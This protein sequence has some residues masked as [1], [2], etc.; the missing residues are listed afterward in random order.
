[1]LSSVRHAAID[2]LR[3][4][5]AHRQAAEQASFRPP[6]APEPPVPA[7]ERRRVA[8]AVDSLPPEQRAVIELAYFQGLSQTQIA[9]RLGEPLGTVKTRLR[10]GM[11]RLRQALLG[12]SE[13]PT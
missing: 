2:R 9:E 7:D 5:E 6:P 3:R 4:R 10:L 12:T 8:R 13:E 11:N 1:V